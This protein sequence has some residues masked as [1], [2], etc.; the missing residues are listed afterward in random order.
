[1][2]LPTARQP[3]EETKKEEEEEEEEEETMVTDIT[4]MAFIVLLYT[5]RQNL[6]SPC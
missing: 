4:F 5:F 2:E 1:M 3:V 6:I